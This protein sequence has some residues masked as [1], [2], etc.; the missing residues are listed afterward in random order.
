MVGA[1]VTV[2]E[3][4]AAELG[5]EATVVTAG[6][7]SGRVISAPR[8]QKP[9]LALTGWDEQL[10]DGRLLILGGTEIAYLDG[11][12]GPARALAIATMLK[13]VPAAVMVA[14]GLAAPP[15]LIAACDAVGVPV[16]ASS[17]ITSDLIVRI[18]NWL[19]ER[20]APQTSIHGVLLDVLGIGILLLGPSGIGKSETALDLVVRGHRLVADD[21]VIIRKKAGF[22]F[23]SGSGIIRHHMEIRGLG[24]INIKDLFGVA[25][26]REAKKVEL[27]VELVEW[28]A[29]EE[30]DRL[31]LDEK[32]YTVLDVQ[33]PMVRLP[34]RPGRNLSTIIEVAARN[35]LLKFQGHHSAR[36][37]Q[38][39]LN[40]AIAEARPARGFDVDVI[41]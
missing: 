24:I 9:G 21:I 11:C 13:A 34:V 31:G 7:G 32:L 30:Y 1:A 37:F 20:M 8:I 23:G 38:E 27:V 14:R 26:I 2:G 41:E 19:A 25:A 33:V 3:L 22:V 4:L 29:N 5:L 10:H 40:Q 16:V 6:A 28:D 12:D 35:Q 36:E 17:L 39:R 18:T 15:E